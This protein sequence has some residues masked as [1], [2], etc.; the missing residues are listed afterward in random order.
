M[1]NRTGRRRRHRRHKRENTARMGSVRSFVRVF[2]LPW[3]ESPQERHR[4]RQSFPPRERRPEPCLFLDGPLAGQMQM[5]EHKRGEQWHRVAQFDGPA[6]DGVFGNACDVRKIVYREK[7]RLH[8][9]PLG[10][11]TLVR[12]EME[13]GEGPY[14]YRET[15]LRACCALFHD[16]ATPAKLTDR[17]SETTCKK[18]L[19]TW[20]R[21]AF[22]EGGRYGAQ[23]S[24]FLDEKSDI[25]AATWDRIRAAM[26]DAE[27]IA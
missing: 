10:G 4:R 20:T 12:V 16:R 14:P 9:G 11:D 7:R 22:T 15:H 24:R 6:T 23:P 3:S 1:T 18:C 5:I 26:T 21:W 19:T 17:V 27:T 8:R 2:G 13:C 25:D